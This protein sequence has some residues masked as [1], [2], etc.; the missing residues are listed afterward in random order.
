[1]ALTE[2]IH[3]IRAEPVAYEPEPTTLCWKPNPYM[4]SIKAKYP[5]CEARPLLSF[6][7]MLGSRSDAHRAYGNAGAG[8]RPR[9]TRPLLSFA[10]GC[11]GA[12]VTRTEQ[13]GNAGTGWRPREA[14][15]LLSFAGDARQPR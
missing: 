4:G 10:G 6:G 12:A 5:T 7:R 9:E 14:R 8:W 15:S 1:M 3:R 11:P 13:P 2:K